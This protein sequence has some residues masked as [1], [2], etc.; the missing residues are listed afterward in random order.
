MASLSPIMEE[1]LSQGN[2]VE[3]IATGISMRPLFEHK[4]SRF[5]P[6]CHQQEKMVN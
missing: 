1:I 6:P 5:D 2:S 3:I 4:V